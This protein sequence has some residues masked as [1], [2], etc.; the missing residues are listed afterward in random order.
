MPI[1]QP[2]ATMIVA[3]RVIVWR[4][5]NFWASFVLQ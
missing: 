4:N 5:K 1:G 3:G 2:T